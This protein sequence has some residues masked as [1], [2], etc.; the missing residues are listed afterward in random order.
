MED[1]AL[2]FATGVALKESETQRWMVKRR[3]GKPSRAVVDRP[4]PAGHEYCG[5]DSAIPV[6]S[7]N[8]GDGE[9]YFGHQDSPSSFSVIRRASMDQDVYEYRTIEIEIEGSGG[10]VDL[11]WVKQRRYPAV[12]HEAPMTTAS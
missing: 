8:R 4:A 5:S 9:A 2:V 10:E 11:E 7:E 1:P 3:P 6:T 12:V